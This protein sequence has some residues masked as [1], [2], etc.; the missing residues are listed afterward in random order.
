MAFQY[1]LAPCSTTVSH[2]RKLTERK[3]LLR[4][5]Q[6]WVSQD[7]WCNHI[8]FHPLP[9]HTAFHR[10]QAL[11]PQWITFWH[12][13]WFGNEVMPKWYFVFG[14]PQSWEPSLYGR[15]RHCF[16]STLHEI[17]LCN[18]M[19][20]KAIWYCYCKMIA[21]WIILFLQDLKSESAGRV[22][23]EVARSAARDH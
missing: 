8:Y 15:V 20:F 18:V 21:S 5:K 19:G 6:G 9:A 16:H 12:P 11:P 1:I 4:F 7:S 14:H 22:V 13:L 3:R 2:A 10:I 17:A 23:V